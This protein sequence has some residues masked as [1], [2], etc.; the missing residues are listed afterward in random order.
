MKCRQYSWA[1]P[2]HEVLVHAQ[3]LAGVEARA[4]ELRNIGD[5]GAVVVDKIG[6]REHGVVA[7]LL[8]VALPGDRSL[9]DKQSAFFGVESV[10]GD[11]ECV[12]E[13][14]PGDHAAGDND[15]VAEAVLGLAAVELFDGRG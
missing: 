6:A 15:I 3:W 4:A 14:A 8:A 12:L 9:V 11:V 7:S 13:E 5:S 2:H 10:C 1:H